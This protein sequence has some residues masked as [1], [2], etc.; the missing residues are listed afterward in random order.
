MKPI[1]WGIIGT[2]SIA[3]QFARSLTLTE[4]GSL[5]AVASRTQ[6]AADR[7]VT[8]YPDAKPCAGYQSI[9]ND[10]D[11]DAVYVATPH[12]MHA[13]WA[14]KAARAGKHVL[15]EKP[16]SINLPE[17]QEMVEEARLA[18][19]V[20]MEAFMY[21]CHPQTAQVVE[22]I[23][24]GAI[25][26]VRLIF[27]S[28][29][30][31]CNG[32][33]NSR[34]LAAELGGGGILDVGCYAMSMA[35]LVAGAAIGQPYADPLELKAVG[36][37]GHAGTDEWSC[38]V[39]SFPNGITAELSCAVNVQ[40][41]NEVVVCG[42]K[43]KIR[44][45]TPWFCSYPHFELIHADGNV[46]PQPV[47]QGLNAYT[48]E[49][50]V[51]ARRIA[52]D[53]DES[54]APSN[55]DTLSNLRALDMWR[56][57]IGLLY[58]HEG[59]TA[60]WPTSDREPLTRNPH[61]KM[62]YMKIPGLPLPVSQIALGTDVRYGLLPLP[63]MA[64]IYDTFFRNGGN[65]YDT[66]HIYQNGLSEQVLGQWI[67]MRGIREQVCILG[68]GAHTPWTNP[69]D[70]GAQILES[71]ERLQTSYIDLY[72][73]HRDNLDYPV[74][75]FMEALNKHI[76]EGRIRAFGVSNWT[77]ERVDEA[78]EY[79]QKHGLRPIVAV[80]NHFSLAPLAKPIGMGCLGAN[81]EESIAWFT[82]RQMPLVAWSAQARGFF[83]RP[84]SLL[85]NP[86]FLDTW[87]NAAN[88][89]MKKRVESLAAE[90]DV[91]PGAVGLAWSLQRP[92]P[93]MPLIGAS[94]SRQLHESLAA[95]RLRLSSQQ[96]AWLEGGD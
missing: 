90:L 65:L 37:I 39:A 23:K 13:E 29:G 11:V 12:P 36:H 32:D 52:G 21:R 80:S 27:S 53:T 60:D 16:L 28:F 83:D 85:A 55:A 20:L 25:G 88:R 72:M 35:R 54:Q 31:Q 63:G 56:H 89:A 92:F 74:S 78:N 17:A 96:M 42:S 19:V 43:G 41:P 94:S 93:M 91:T 34:L 95:L 87:N 18:G 79:C 57:Q 14:I 33:E 64:V 46:I 77:L 62:P 8:E 10:P 58:P 51:M 40:L 66:A 45:I 49:A 67:K 4:S 3:K 61:H 73:M 48:L 84:D 86:D 82:D 15:C 7:F 71:L 1:R 75:A 5:V 30:F 26:E 76:D 59:M 50:E 69:E 38:A 2:G 9:L 70:M 22:L 44:V 68:K 6:E 24:S 81:D 47:P